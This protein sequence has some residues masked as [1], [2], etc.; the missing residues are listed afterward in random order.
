MSTL[1]MNLELAEVKRIKK[2][3]IVAT[4]IAIVTLLLCIG[5]GYH[6][7]YEAIMYAVM[8]GAP[9]TGGICSLAITK[10]VKALCSTSNREDMVDAVMFILVSKWMLVSTMFLWLASFIIS[11]TARV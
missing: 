7:V 2:W 3:A 8:V 4:V 5:Y 6:D 1:E 9:L 11:V 10:R